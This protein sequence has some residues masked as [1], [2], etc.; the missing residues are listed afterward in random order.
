MASQCQEY[1]VDLD[2]YRDQLR[3]LEIQSRNTVD[4]HQTEVEALQASLEVER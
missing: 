2:S 1:Q 4:Q 3:D